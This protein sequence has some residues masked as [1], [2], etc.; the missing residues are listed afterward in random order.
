MIYFARC[1]RDGPI[2][3]GH[4][5]ADVAARISFLQ[6]GCPWQL[7]VIG[8]MEGDLLTEASLLSQF[9]HLNIRGEWF[10]ATAELISFIE[11]NANDVV[12]DQPK[13]V[14]IPIFSGETI[15]EEDW[16]TVIHQIL[17][18][19]GW[20]Q[21]QLASALGMQQAM[22]SK[23]RNSKHGPSKSARIILRSLLADA[24]KS[25]SEVAA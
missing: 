12:K 21:T 5:T 17:T 18:L 25:S 7:I 2:K 14:V 6:V 3:I 15:D 23:W 24:M 4:T 22:V 8:T 20:T 19:N 13:R 10:H 16:P 11:H 9:S 1:G